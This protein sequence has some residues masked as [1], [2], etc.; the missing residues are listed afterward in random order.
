MIAGYEIN[1]FSFVFYTTFRIDLLQGS[2][3]ILASAP[4]R[5]VLHV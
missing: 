5:C 1:I 2:A 3:G 4:I